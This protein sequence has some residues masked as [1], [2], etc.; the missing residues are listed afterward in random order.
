MVAFIFSFGPGKDQ[1]KVKVGQI[2]SNFK[3]QN[4]LPKTDISYRHGYDSESNHEATQN[5]MLF[6]GVMS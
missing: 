4:F 1:Y 2:R 3:N 5:E 6:A